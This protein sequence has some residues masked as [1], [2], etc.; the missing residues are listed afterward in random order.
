MWLMVLVN[1]RR[2][3]AGAGRIP[4]RATALPVPP[5]LG[6]LPRPSTCFIRTNPGCTRDFASAAFLLTA[7]PI[8]SRRNS[9]L[10]YEAGQF[11]A[12]DFGRKS[13][14]QSEREMKLKERLV[15]FVNGRDQ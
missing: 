3:R 11:V 7:R 1:D 4:Q 15:R 9:R 2:Y 5:R 12:S 6:S 10:R 13:A 8:A 14:G